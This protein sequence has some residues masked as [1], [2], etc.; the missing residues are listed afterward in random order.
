M[1]YSP[2]NAAGFHIGIVGLGGI[3]GGVLSH[4]ARS[5]IKVVGWDVDPAAR[6]RAIEAGGALA[7]GLADLA[8]RAPVIFTSLPSEAAVRAVYLEKDGLVGCGAEILTCDGSTVSLELAGEIA[9]R[10]SENGG[11]HVEAAVVG[12]N[13]DAAAGNLHLFLAG[14]DANIAR[15]DPLLKAASAGHTRF[16][17]PG[18]AALAKI[19]NN[20]LGLATMACVGESLAIAEQAGLDAGT[21]VKAIL[22]GHGAGW[23]VVL[24]RHGET[25]AKGVDL[26]TGSAPITTKDARALES[27]ISQYSVVAPTLSLAAQEVL[28]AISEQGCKSQWVAVARHARSAQSGT[29]T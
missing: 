26:P 1:S 25:M 20:G 5:G 9:R 2:E 21:V 14:D 15:L 19:L 23:S 8:A 17:Q 22:D 27:A 10:R 16:R 12:V 6:D 11:Q 3:G 24:E 13:K 28:T 29:K 7:T 18:H 4:L